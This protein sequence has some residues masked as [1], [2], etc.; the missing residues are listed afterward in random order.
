MQA[1]L[2]TL[3]PPGFGRGRGMA[4]CVIPPPRQSATHILTFRFPIWNGPF[5][6]GGTFELVPTHPHPHG[7]TLRITQLKPPEAQRCE[8]NTKPRPP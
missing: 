1:G 6:P 5:S 3:D 7:H 4:K 2:Q 8:S